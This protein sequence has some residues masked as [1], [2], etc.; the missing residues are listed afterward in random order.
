MLNSVIEAPLSVGDSLGPY[1]IT[2]ALGAGGMGHV[3]RAHDSRL[4]RSV[5]IK[6]LRGQYS[7]RFQR[8]AKAI[9][10]LN[11]PNICTLHDVGANY[12]VMELVEGPTLADRIAHGAVPL[13]E[14]LAI[15]R[16]IAAALE[17]AHERGIVH[18]DLKPAN[19][20]IQPNGQAKVLDFGLATIAVAPLSQI[21]EATQ[22]MTLTQV[23]TVMGTPPYMTPEQAQ[24]KPVDK[25]ADIH[26][27]LRRRALRN[28]D[29]PA[30]LHGRIHTGHFGRGVDARAGVERC[31]G[32]GAA[33]VTP[34][35]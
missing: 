14:A 22:T 28:A 7:E 12:L 1:R 15:A 33:A 10:A 18:R 17:A 31:A 25:R 26:L 32:P 3:Y 11:H 21:A 5:A 34:V 6:I 8:E 35:P 23:G 30:A 13:D 2:S 24:G 9:A 20:K 19:I 16:Q 29:G 4:G 27:G